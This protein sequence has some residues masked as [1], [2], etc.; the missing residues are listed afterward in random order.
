MSAHT[1][2]HDM[3]LAPFQIS[4]PGASGTFNLDNKGLVS[5]AIVTAT[6]EARTLPAPN[7]QYDGQT[8]LLYLKTDGGDCT[9]TVT[10]GQGVSTVVLDDAGDWVLL[11]SIDVGGTLKWV[12]VAS[13]GVASGVNQTGGGNLTVPGNLAVTG[14]STLTGAVSMAGNTL[15]TGAGAGITD[16]TGTIYKNSVLKNGGIFCTQV[17]IDLTGVASSTTD[18]DIIGT[19]TSAAYIAKLTAA[20]CGTTILAVSM[21]CLEAPAGGIAD[22][23]LYSATEGTGKFDDGVAGLTETAL[24]TAGGSWTNG[25]TKGATVA[26]L[27]T[28]YIYLTGGAAGTAATYTAGK[29]LITIYGY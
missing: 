15:A 17:M 14:T 3:L 4:D 28:E 23:D 20:E 13:N 5:C 6:A 12:V 2:P 19:G 18:L 24:I 10:T 11:K 1:L 27:S 7:T 25:L 29:F 22:I 16:G 9:I 8:A 26:P 21:Q